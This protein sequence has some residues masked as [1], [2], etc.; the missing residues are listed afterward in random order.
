MVKEVGVIEKV[1]E[2]T[3]FVR[4]RR[5]S[6][7]AHCEHRAMCDAES[8]NEVLLEMTNDLQAHV[9]DRVEISV[10]TRSLVKLSLLV[11]M[12]PVFALILGAYAGGEWAN[13]EGMHPTLASILG[14]GMAFVISLF[15]LKRLDRTEKT[16][17]E[18]QPRMTRVLFSATSP[19]SRGDNK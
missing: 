15:F 18:Y 14:G 3:A 19:S 2:H 17:R 5:S 11:Y 1:R 12:L 8:T 10:P 6:G 16:K 4:V 13:L 9:D 7:C